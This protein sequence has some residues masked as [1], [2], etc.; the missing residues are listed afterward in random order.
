[1][2]LVPLNIPPL[3]QE[4]LSRPA[5]GWFRRVVQRLDPAALAALDAGTAWWE[6]ELIG[7]EP[8]WQRFQSFPPARP[9]PTEQAVVDELVAGFRSRAM[10]RTRPKAG[11][12]SSR[13]S[14]SAFRTTTAAWSGRRWRSRRRWRG[15]PPSTRCWRAHRRA[16]TG[17]PGS[18]CCGVTARGTAEPLAATLRCRRGGGRRAG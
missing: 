1:L 16:A 13:P 3:R 12:A 7:G 4:W 6:A 9:L 10:R 8:D 14:A 11:C 2:V 17:W 5:L 15:S 18:S